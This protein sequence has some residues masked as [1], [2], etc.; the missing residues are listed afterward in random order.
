M[1]R[2]LRELQAPHSS[3]ELTGSGED[4][5]D[6]W[7]DSM[8]TYDHQWNPKFEPHKSPLEVHAAIGDSKV[9]GD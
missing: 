9:C 1:L 6:V 3:Q 5:D 7:Q 8:R 2:E 4:G